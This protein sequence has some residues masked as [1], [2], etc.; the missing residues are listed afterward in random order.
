MGGRG[1]SVSDHS[2]SENEWNHRSPGVAWILQERRRSTASSCISAEI[3][4]DSRHSR[5]VG[6]RRMDIDDF[7]TLS[8]TGPLNEETTC[9]PVNVKMFDQ[10]RGLVEEPLTRMLEPSEEERNR[11]VYQKIRDNTMPLPRRDVDNTS[12]FRLGGTKT[13]KG[14]GGVKFRSRPFGRE[15]SD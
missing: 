4:S 14:S 11:G 12:C 15:A 3:H 13:N 10:S 6:R 7:P 9:W 5:N 2:S 8:T 1:N